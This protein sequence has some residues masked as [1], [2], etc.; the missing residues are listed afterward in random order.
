MV[1]RRQWT[2]IS[3]CPICNSDSKHH[4]FFEG[5][6]DHDIKLAY[7][8]CDM[9]GFV[10]QN[11]RPSEAFLDDFYRGEYRKVVQGSEGPTDKDLRVQWGRANHLISFLQTSG[12]RPEKVLDIGSS[13]GVLLQ[14]MKEAFGSEV[15]GIEPG[16]AYRLWSR[17]HG[18][19]IH[20]TIEDLPG[21]HK[22]SFEMIS[23]I[24]VIEHLPDLIPYLH[25]IRSKWL[26]P[27][28][29][30]LIEVPNLFAHASL[31]LAHLSAFTGQSLSNLLR[32]AE[33]S[34]QVIQ[35]H[36]APRSPV[37]KLY[38]TTLASVDNSPPPL[39]IRWSGS[40]NI[41]RQRKIGKWINRILTRAFPRLTWRS[42]PS[43]PRKS[44]QGN[45]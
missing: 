22:H 33:F 21:T 43:L 40:N 24:H 26:R 10:F 35:S 5:R 11:P 4:S 25:E 23:L 42:L 37:L 18:L 45:R 29:F 41:R 16:D 15:Y 3:N 20:K 12:Y 9:C 13:T 38:L 28:G 19:E 27:E 2:I 14:Q 7:R 30:L 44:S 36:G 1:T 39:N 17:K 31:E 34:V 6:V 8:I 32:M